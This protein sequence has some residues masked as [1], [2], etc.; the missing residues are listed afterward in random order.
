MTRILRELSFEP[1]AAADPT[2][3]AVRAT[4]TVSG[5]A[6]GA[7]EIG[8]TGTGVWQTLPTQQ[9]GNRLVARIDDAALPA[10]TYVLRARAHDNAGNESSTDRR[11]DGL[12]M[13]VTLP[14]RSPQRYAP[15]LRPR[16]VAA[17][18]AGGR[19]FYGLR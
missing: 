12:P 19:S 16:C 13:V 8:A 9:N 5:L 2:L 7:I 6:G 15:A 14:L 3:I 1:A 11:V 18:S 4:D 10:G 17:A